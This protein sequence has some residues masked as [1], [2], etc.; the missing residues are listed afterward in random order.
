MTLLPLPEGAWWD[1][2]V[3]GFDGSRLTL[4]AGHDL[5][6]HHELEIELTDTLY[7]RC[8]TA[9]ADPEFREPTPEEWAEAVRA[10]GGEPPV[11]LAFEADGG[12]TGPVS[13][14]I[15][16]EAWAMRQGRFP[17]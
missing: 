12:G 6:Y 2:E 10:V 8:P 1:W 3:R 15:A 17:R 9:F 13:C 14:L 5:A 11:L 4:V 16:A 7:V